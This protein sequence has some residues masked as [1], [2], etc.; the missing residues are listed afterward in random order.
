MR[1]KRRKR[2]KKRRRK[3]R[4]TRKMR[5]RRRKKRKRRTRRKRTCPA[6]TNS[7]KRIRQKYLKKLFEIYANIN[8]PARL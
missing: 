6:I 3:R 8:C 4:R 2:T 5:K 1:S 7:I